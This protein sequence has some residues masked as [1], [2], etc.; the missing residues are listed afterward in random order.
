MLLKIMPLAADIA[1]DF[2]AIRQTNASHLAKRGV[3]L[4]GRRGIHARADTPPL[5]A[6]LQRGDVTLRCLAA[7]R[8]ANQL[9]DRC[10]EPLVVSE[11]EDGRSGRRT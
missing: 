6:L 9:I 7:T 2:K 8:L 3:W 10:H 5:W 4:L 11:K 1:G